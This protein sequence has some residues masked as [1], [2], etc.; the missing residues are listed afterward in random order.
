MQTLIGAYLDGCL[1]PVLRR[2]D[3]ERVLNGSAKSQQQITQT[4]FL[5]QDPGIEM[6]LRRKDG[7]FGASDC[8]KLY[9]HLHIN[10]VPR[11]R[12]SAKR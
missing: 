5:V 12:P 10:A 11:N 3:V 4:R 1:D 2:E 7:E 9:R 8:T 6:P